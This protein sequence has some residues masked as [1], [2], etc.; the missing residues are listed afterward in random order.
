MEGR[1]DEEEVYCRSYLR[2]RT[3]AISSVSMVLVCAISALTSALMSALKASKAVSC[4]GE[5]ARVISCSDGEAV[6]T[7]SGSMVAG[8]LPAFL[9]PDAMA[10]ETDVR[11]TIC[12]AKG[13]PMSNVLKT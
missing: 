7:S 6:L 4:S 13:S 10:N 11:K 1:I 2:R 12:L 9:V 3:S 5:K 8:C